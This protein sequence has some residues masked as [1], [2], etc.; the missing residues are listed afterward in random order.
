MMRLSPSCPTVRPEI[1]ND[2]SDP[3]SQTRLNWRLWDKLKFWTMPMGKTISSLAPSANAAPTNELAPPMFAR[4]GGPAASKVK[5]AFRN[6]S[7]YESCL[8][9][10][11]KFPSG[12]GLYL[13]PLSGAGRSWGQLLLALLMTLVSEP[14]AVLLR[15]LWLG[16]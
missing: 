7:C 8:D 5:L 9:S 3:I 2:L 11:P 15:F 14:S 13:H 1:K 6:C 10:L 16:C 12:I 4:R